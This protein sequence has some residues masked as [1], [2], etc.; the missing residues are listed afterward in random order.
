MNARVIGKF[1]H[2]VECLLIARRLRQIVEQRADAEPDAIEFI[3]SFEGG[4]AKVSTDVITAL[5]LLKVMVEVLTREEPIDANAFEPS[6]EIMELFADPRVERSKLLEIRTAVEK[7]QQSSKPGVQ[8][9]FVDR[10][11][12]ALNAK[13]VDTSADDV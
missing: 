10:F 6:K 7:A 3:I 13:E 12:R 8:V 2:A 9:R 11:G 1:R 4:T 5:P